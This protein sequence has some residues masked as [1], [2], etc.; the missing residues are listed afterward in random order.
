METINLTFYTFIRDYKN[1]LAAPIFCWKHICSSCFCT[2]SNLLN[3]YNLKITFGSVR[4]TNL[5]KQ[6]LQTRCWIMNPRIHDCLDWKIRGF[7]I[8]SINLQI[9][10]IWAELDR[11]H[12]ISR[13]ERR[14]M[15]EWGIDICLSEWVSLGLLIF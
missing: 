12:E 14:F 10:C 4:T 3:S 6:T 2:E 1:R 11:H 5:S 7:M 8:I 13:K 9:E 15:F